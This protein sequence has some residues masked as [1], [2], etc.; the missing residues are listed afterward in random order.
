MSYGVLEG[1]GEGIGDERA[2]RECRDRPEGRGMRVEQEVQGEVEGARG[3][4][5]D[6]QGRVSCEAEAEVDCARRLS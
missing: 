5:Q 1:V 4:E 2:R 6:G 3:A